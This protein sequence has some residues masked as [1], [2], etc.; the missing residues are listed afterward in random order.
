MTTALTPLTDAAAPELP[1]L[2]LS[3]LGARTTGTIEPATVLAHL[4]HLRRVGAAWRWIVGDLVLALAAEAGDDLAAAWQQIAALDLDDRPS[5]MKSVA[6]AQ[7]V[8][9]ERRRAELSWSHH[10]AVAGLPAT[11]QEE[12]LAGA[13]VNGWT[14]RHLR[15]ALADAAAA[16]EPSP[17][18]LGDPDASHRRRLPRAT[19]SALEDL[20]AQQ[21]DAAVVLHSD[22]SWRALEVT[23]TDG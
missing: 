18:Q 8:P 11:Q 14:V 20:W 22:G 1:G 15:D 4:G 17:A 13:I 9:L 19:L 10:E 23:A 7:R 12:W 2:E 6:V 3:E 16:E 21:P 5:L